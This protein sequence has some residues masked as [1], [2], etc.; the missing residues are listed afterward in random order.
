M[1]GT[2]G[3]SAQRVGGH[4]VTQGPPLRPQHQH[5]RLQGTKQDR[6]GLTSICLVHYLGVLLSTF[7]IKQAKHDKMRSILF[8]LIMVEGNFSK[9]LAC[10]EY[11]IGQTSTLRKCPTLSHLLMTEKLHVFTLVSRLKAVFFRSCNARC[12]NSNA[13]QSTHGRPGSKTQKTKRNN[14]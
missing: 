8:Q 12:M 2:W 9:I 11:I 6:H 5:L 3:L 13:W 10:I 1:G 7:L 4:A 14:Y